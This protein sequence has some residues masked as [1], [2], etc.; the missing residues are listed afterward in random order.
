MKTPFF[1]VNK[2]S[3]RKVCNFS[4]LENGVYFLKISC[5]KENGTIK[6]VKERQNRCDN[7]GSLLG[8]QE[9][10]GYSRSS[11]GNWIG[12]GHGRNI[13]HAVVKQLNLQIIINC[14]IN[15]G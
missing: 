15:G 4:G 7:D 2:K 1:A 6:F 14:I 3:F 13:L 11:V 9:P 8:K 12:V 5:G 10:K